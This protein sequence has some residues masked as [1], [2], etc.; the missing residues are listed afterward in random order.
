MCIAVP[1]R[2][3]HID[4]LLAEVAVDER[5]R[6]VSLS[7]LSDP[8]A[9]GDFVTLQAGRYAVSAMDAEEAHLR[10]ELFA[11]IGAIERPSTEKLS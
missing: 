7:L 3:L 11:E 5:R 1:C 4:G 9:V 2:V 6:T 8:V 10:L